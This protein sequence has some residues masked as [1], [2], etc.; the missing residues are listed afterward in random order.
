MSGFDWFAVAVA[1]EAL[2]AWGCYRLG[3]AR[4]VAA[5][6]RFIDG[7]LARR[8]RVAAGLEEDDRGAV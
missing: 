8:R 6:A 4:G 5:L 1:A 2:T 3:F 7:E